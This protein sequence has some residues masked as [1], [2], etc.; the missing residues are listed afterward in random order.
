[1]QTRYSIDSIRYQRMTT[2]ELRENFLVEDLFNE[3]KLDL[4]YWENERTVIGSAKP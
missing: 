3:G 1:M 4:L 2:R